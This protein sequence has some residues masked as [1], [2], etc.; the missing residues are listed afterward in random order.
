MRSSSQIAQPRKSAG[1][2]LL[3]STSAFNH[4]STM[5]KAAMPQGSNNSSSLILQ[6]QP[7]QRAEKV[8]PAK[9]AR[10]TCVLFESEKQQYGDRCPKGY[11]K[12]RLLGKG[13]CAVVWLGKDNSTG[14]RVALKQFPKTK[15]QG[16]DKSAQAEI[17]IWEK[18]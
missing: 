5:R 16:I 18:I 7:L 14:Q 11:A 12:L 17:T 2:V 3:A 9:T 1:S 10:A 6:R 4:Q 15:G 8:A 13:G